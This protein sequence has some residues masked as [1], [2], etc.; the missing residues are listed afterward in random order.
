[1]LIDKYYENL[2][3]LHVNT[4]PV[5]SYYIPASGRMELRGEK[6]QNSDRMKLLSGMWKFKY[7]P[8]LYQLP[9]AF[10]KAEEDISEYKDVT[11]PGMW[12][13]YGYDTHQ[14]MNFQYPFPYDPPYVPYENPCGTYIKEFMYEPKPE[15]PRVFLNFEGV[16]SCL[17]VWVNGTFAGYSQV[18]HATSEFDISDYIKEGKNRLAVLVLKWCDGSYLEDQ[19]KFRMSGIFRDVYLLY[20]PENCIY[21]YIIKT[22]PDQAYETAGLDISLDFLNEVIPVKYALYDADDMLVAEGISHTGKIHTDIKEAHLWNAE[23]PYLYTLIMQT[24]SETIT[25]HVGIR[26]IYVDDGVLYING[27]AVKF[28]GVNR[29]DFDPRTGYVIDEASITKDLRMMKEHNLNAIRTSHYPNAPH[30]YDLYDYYGFYIMGEAD[31]ESHG[32]V[33]LYKNKQDRENELIPWRPKRIA[34]NPKFEKSILDRIKRSV[35][36]EKN[37]PSIVIWSMGN[38]CA[39]GCNFEAALK[40]TKEYDTTR[41]THYEGA[42]N[43]EDPEQYDY[44][45]LDV[46]SRMYTSPDQVREYFADG[47]INKPYVLCEY[48]MALGNGPGDLEDYW[49]AMNEYDGMCGGFIWQWCEHAIYMGKNTEGKEVYAYGGEFGETPNDGYFCLNGLAAPDRSILPGLLEC[50]NVNR[51]VRI[52]SSEIKKESGQCEIVLKNYMHFTNVK[53]FLF[54]TYELRQNGCLLQSGEITEENMP[55]IGPGMEEKLL[56]DINIPKAGKVYLLF[57][58][59]LCRSTSLLEKDYEVGFEEIEIETEDRRFIIPDNALDNAHGRESIRKGLKIERDERYIS[60]SSDLLD[61]A[62]DTYTGVL[63]RMNIHN[64]RYLE[65]PVRYNIWQAPL[66]TDREVIEE[67]RRA[68]YPDAYARG[69]E[70]A[71]KLEDNRVCIH[72][73]AALAASHTQR[74]MDIDSNWMICEDGTVQVDIS[75][76]RTPGFPYLP[77]FGLRLFLPGSM[78]DVTYFGLGPTEN[79]IDMHQSCYHALFHQRVRDMHIDFIYPHENGSRSDCSYLCLKSA[80]QLLRVTS[81]D[82]FSFNV[83][84]YTQEEL[85]KKKHNY[86]LQESPYTVLCLD[87]KQTGCG[88]F[89]GPRLDRRYRL[90]EDEFDFSLEIKPY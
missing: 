5:R 14:Y 60:I 18:S 21:D 81:P 68:M 56:L 77:R 30:F 22:T 82:A 35:I 84:H 37:R 89:A 85:E 31:N 11:V 39:Y 34:D 49:K 27:K 38:E 61:Y 88:S 51:P 25:E 86:E 44:S 55:D 24:E 12:Q 75:V 33:E 2:D 66:E 40:W 80:S 65:M 73:Q 41:L 62:F 63:S 26:C 54:L 45:N 29:H 70:T 6:R 74:I 78:E 87:Y 1:M 15:A 42:I 47:K 53:H 90:D 76:K 69:L 72:S 4:M 46:Y 9:H 67:Q 13:M 10:Y 19:D 8:A 48:S 20:R 50:K 28:H 36:R 7:Y 58:Y 17:Y 57:K 64:Q 71:V 59:H 23:D 3:V 79:Y 16:D 83:S 32:T 43:I 52:I